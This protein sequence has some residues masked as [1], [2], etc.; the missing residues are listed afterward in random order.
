MDPQPNPLV[1]ELN[2]E[3]YAWYNPYFPESYRGLPEPAGHRVY[4][5]N[6]Q[7]R[8]HHILT[9]S[10]TGY[11]VFR[12]YLARAATGH[13]AKKY[14]KKQDK[15]R[16]FYE[17]INFSDAEGVIGPDACEDLYMDFGEHLSEFQLYLE[18]E[19]PE[20]RYTRETYINNYVE[21]LVGLRMIVQDRRDGLYGMIIFR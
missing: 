18:Q 21:F 11:G 20:S 6:E 5:L 15:A 8:T 14:W 12:E 3:I 17:L 16:P 7:S 9:K 13:G 2:D 10:Y 4:Q 19:I 1:E